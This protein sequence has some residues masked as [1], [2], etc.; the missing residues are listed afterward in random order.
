MVNPMN[1]G[2]Y[3]AQMP[4]QAGMIMPQAQPTTAANEFGTF[5]N[6][7]YA[8]QPQPVAQQTAVAQ[9]PVVP[10]A[11]APVAPQNGAP[12]VDVTTFTV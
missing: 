6:P 1:T 10:Q 3:P 2:A 7:A 11:T 8:P 9:N 12:N 5:G 4:P